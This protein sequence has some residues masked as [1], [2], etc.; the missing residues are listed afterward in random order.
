VEEPD[1]PL[2]A[3]LRR[4]SRARAWKGNEEAFRVAESLRVGL[5]DMVIPGG[6][7]EVQSQGSAKAIFFGPTQ[8]ELDA[9]SV[10][11]GNVEPAEALAEALPLD[12]DFTNPQQSW[13]QVSM[14]TMLRRLRRV[15]AFEGEPRRQALA[16]EI[17]T[18]LA[19]RLDGDLCEHEAP[20][21]SEGS[22]TEDPR[23]RRVRVDDELFLMKRRRAFSSEVAAREPAAGLLDDSRALPG[24]GMKCMTQ[25]EL[26]ALCVEQDE[27]PIATC[28]AAMATEG[29]EEN[30]DWHARSPLLRASGE[31]KDDSPCSRLDSL[32]SPR[33]FSK[34]GSPSS[35]GRGGA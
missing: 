34:F 25:E 8:S 17:G 15:R 6:A 35:P 32:G 9:L 29:Y 27:G 21:T 18:E 10:D 2:G 11:D 30:D 22:E 23:H 19:D 4:I 5:A 31:G 20:D 12:G 28:A 26:D 16:A 1:S 24:L 3:A 7:E 33:H 13:H 14:G